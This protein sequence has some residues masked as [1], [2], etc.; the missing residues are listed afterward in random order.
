[1]SYWHI[2]NTIRRQIPYDSNADEKIT[3]ANILIEKLRKQFTNIAFDNITSGT[4][5]SDRR[6]IIL[7]EIESLK[8]K[9]KELQIAKQPIHISMLP[10]DVM[11]I[12]FRHYMKGT[13]RQN[14][15]D[16]WL[17]NLFMQNSGH[18]TNFYDESSTDDTLPED[19]ILLNK[20]YVLLLNCD[21]I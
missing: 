12:I 1:M 16:A 15:N 18:F 11:Y 13:E 9:I 21:L 10:I 19:Y 17:G 6:K 14:V 3:K 20:T 4:N 8:T 7:Q 2:T 5:S